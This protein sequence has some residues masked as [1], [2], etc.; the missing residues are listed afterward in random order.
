MEVLD[1]VASTTVQTL[2]DVYGFDLDR[3]FEAVQAL[4]KKDDLSLAIDWLLQHGEEDKGGA[5]A[6]Q[7]CPHLDVD[8]TPL[9]APELLR[10]GAPCAEGCLSKENWVCLVCGQTACSRY[11]SSHSLA[12]FD[13][14]QHRIAISLGDMS[15]WCYKCNAYVE[16]PRL[17]AL[18]AHMQSL[19]FGSSSAASVCGDCGAAPA[20]TVSTVSSKA[21]G[22]RPAAQAPIMEEA[23]D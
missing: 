11:V 21:A 8:D 5:V 18:T 17:E 15:T 2:V 16:H 19:K 9:V 10:Y 13:A 1:P 20:G 22:K 14:T 7:H 23:D 12:H 3:S 4:G 6:F